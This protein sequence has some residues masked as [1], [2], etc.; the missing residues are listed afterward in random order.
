MLAPVTRVLDAPSQGES[1]ATHTGTTSNFGPVDTAVM[2]S[3][4]RLV[5]ATTEFYYEIV[6]DDDEF[7]ASEPQTGMYGEGD[8]QEEA[9]VS[10]LQSLANLREELRSHGE[11][12]SP[13]LRADLAFLNQIL[14]A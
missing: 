8:S 6:A 1:T 9:V 12:L 14:W 7:V 13:E 3:Q 2:R 4:G 10:L 11:E 5:M